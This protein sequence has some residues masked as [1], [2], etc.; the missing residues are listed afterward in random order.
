MTTDRTEIVAY[1]LCLASASPRRSELLRGL[2]I[3]PRLRPVDVDERPGANELPE[4]LVR[5]LSEAK[6]RLALAT[7]TALPPRS[8]LLGADT[9]V[10]LGAEIF[11]KPANPEEA[12]SML[13]R[14]NGRSHQVLTG[15]CLLRVDTDGWI[16]EVDSTEVR[17]RTVDD[18]TLARYV[19]GGEP[20]DKAG[21]YAIQGTGAALIDSIDGS[22]ATVVGL[23]VERLGS[24]LTRLGLR[25]GADGQITLCD[26]DL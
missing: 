13:R 11:G 25:L 19:A 15:T 17:F 23:P 18:E 16:N 6:V 8:V 22:W 20:L 24:W 21:A 5:R 10:V 9:V 3:T 4:A 14:L 12:Q 2:G 26:G 7:D 1:T